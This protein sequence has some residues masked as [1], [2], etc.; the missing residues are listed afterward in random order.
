MMASAPT[1]TN[2]LSGELLFGE[3]DNPYVSRLSPM[4][5]VHGNGAVNTASLDG[6]STSS[7]PV[8]KTGYLRGLPGKKRWRRLYI[9]YSMADVGAVGAVTTN[10]SI[11]TEPSE[12]SQY[13]QSGYLDETVGTI[14]K[15][16][17][18][19][20]SISSLPLSEGVVVQV[21]SGSAL[22]LGNDFRVYKI[23]AEVHP[24]EQSR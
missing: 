14:R 18:S 8:V 13:Q 17:N 12:T 23:E 3:R 16:I 6:N 15:R 24:L 19:L 22:N 4:W 20:G 21:G 10:A 7:A 2:S 11:W 5:L 1:S 9:T